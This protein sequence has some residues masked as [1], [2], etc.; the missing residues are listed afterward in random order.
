VTAIIVPQQ[1]ELMKAFGLTADFFER[2]EV[3]IQDEKMKEWLQQEVKKYN[4]DI[5]KYARI[6]DF[7]MK[8][9]PF[10]VED[11]DMT[12]TLKIKRKVVME[13]YSDQIESMY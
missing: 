4:E 12:I 8:R 3:F 5:A 2:E 1:E 7:V 10:S 13:K 11:G 6:K 9:K